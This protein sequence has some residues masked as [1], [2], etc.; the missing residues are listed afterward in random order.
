MQKR[1]EQEEQVRQLKIIRAQMA[2]MGVFIRIAFYLFSFLCVLGLLASA[3]LPK[4][5]L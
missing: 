1:T 5:G 4:G 2:P 3:F